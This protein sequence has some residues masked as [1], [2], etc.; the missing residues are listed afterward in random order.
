MSL[1]DGVEE[2]PHPRVRDELANELLGAVEAADVH[3]FIGEDV[4]LLA[5]R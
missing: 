5:R 2:G 1:E 3:L 4:R